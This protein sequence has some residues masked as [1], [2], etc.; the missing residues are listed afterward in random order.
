M[1][2]DFN[3]RYEFAR[4]LA[5]QVLYL[6][7][8]AGKDAAS[9]RA[10]R[11]ELSEVLRETVSG[12]GELLGLFV[13][14]EP[15]A[16]DGRDADFVGQQAL[17][18]ND[19]G[20]FALYWLQPS[21]GQLQAVPGDEKLLADRSPG[22][23]G[24]PFNAFIT[25]SRDSA[26]ACLLEPYQDDSSGT[27]HL[28]TSITVPL[29]EQGRVVAVLGLDISLDTLQKSAAA[30]AAGLYDG[31]GSVAIV[32]AGGLV[33]AHSQHRELPG[34]RLRDVQPDQ[35]EALMSALTKGQ[36][37]TLEDPER[38]G[39]LLPIQPIADAPSWGVLVS[40]SRAAL[41][42]PVTAMQ[43]QMQEQ[44]LHSLTLQLAIG[45]AVALLG[46]VLVWLTARSVT[47]PIQQVARLLEDIA[48]GD[49]DLTRRLAHPGRDELG[50]LS[51]AFDRFLGRLQPVI[52]QVQQAVGDTRQT[53]DQSRLIASQTS[54]G[55]QQQFHEIE[56]M[57]A[58]LQQMS[59]TAQ[60][61]AQSAAQ[62]ADAARHADQAT[63]SGLLVIERTTRGIH[64]LA[65]GMNDGMARLQA[66]AQ[67][68]DQ[69]GSVMDVILSIA[70]QTNLLALNAAI[71]AA[72]AGDA[73]R[74]FAVVADEVRGLA[75]RT[76]A[77]VEE[78]GVVIDNLRL[79][80]RDVTVAMQ[81][82]HEQAQGN[83]EQAR[84]AFAALERIRQA[85]TV[86]T[87]MNVQIA[88]AAEEQSNVAS[89]IRRNV[90]A[91][92]DVTASLSDQAERSADISEQL[93][94]LATRQ[95]GLIQ[96]FRT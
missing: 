55:M 70:R 78:I 21:L 31:Q 96:T 40:A 66:L 23:S 32:S 75:Q 72:R 86:I 27:P 35:A 30:T 45:L 53:A 12:H 14:F 7:A 59:A 88:C 36:A 90:E 49:G 57:A 92:R 13:A 1:Q 5:E 84:Q 87:D 80:T 26:R 77:S 3:R 85:V 29:I 47:R 76:Q 65:G 34:K 74:G 42:A 81:H 95:Q 50:R 16:L 48:E 60:G 93:N 68:S 25:C 46:I 83:A 17:G 38:I 20:R 19:R 94:T 91:V 63:G 61:A 33:A 44:R 62:A 11:Q 52:A 51:A 9:A 39:V 2:Q 28:V 54:L 15:N 22:P 82:S 69:I 37:R 56:Q 8:R 89:E 24:A 71:E 67:S 64:D 10:L 73:G 58:A 79:G 18:S 41:E 43:Q 6:R 4:S